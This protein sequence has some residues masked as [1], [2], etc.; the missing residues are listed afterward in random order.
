LYERYLSFLKEHAPRQATTQ[1]VNQIADDLFEASATHPSTAQRITL[2]LGA[3]M[4]DAPEHL[5]TLLGEHDQPSSAERLLGINSA[6]AQE[7]GSSFEAAISSRWESQRLYYS[8]VRT[9]LAVLSSKDSLTLAERLERAELLTELGSEE[10]AIAEYRSILEVSP[11]CDQASIH[12][13]ALLLDSDLEEG[14]EIAKRFQSSEA[15]DVR[16]LTAAAYNF[17]KRKNDPVLEREMAEAYHDAQRRIEQAYEQSSNIGP[18]DR[19]GPARLEPEPRERLI[20]FLRGVRGLKKAYLMRKLPESPLAQE[21]YV[22]LAL[23]KY[24]WASWFSY[25]LAPDNTATMLSKLQEGAE[26]PSPCIIFV[27]SEGNEWLLKKMEI[28]P[29]ACLV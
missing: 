7:V 21:V 5:L 16:S 26:V 18:N 9:R 3:E 1:E 17:W 25:G 11:N 15:H 24:N 14:F 28:D 12:L 2:L 8:E 4:K 29:S 27:G 13:G 6:L 23:P 20:T 19:F 22:L 10:Q